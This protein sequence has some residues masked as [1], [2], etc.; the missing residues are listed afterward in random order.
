MSGCIGASRDSRYSGT[1]RGVGGIKSI[2][3]LLGGVDG[4]LGCQRVSGSVG[5]VRGIL[6]G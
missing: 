3:K 2:G 6:G 4:H 5:D 1:R